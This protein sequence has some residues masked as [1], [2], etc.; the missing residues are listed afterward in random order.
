MPSLF[1][2]FATL[3]RGAR[4]ALP[5]LHAAVETAK[6][7]SEILAEAKELGFTIR[8][9]V[10]LDIIGTLRGNLDVRRYLRI[11]P[12]SAILNPDFIPS[13]IS[14]TLR[15]FSYTVLARMHDEETG[16]TINQHITVSSNDALSKEDIL[17][18]A[19]EYSLSGKYGA[20]IVIDNLSVTNAVK[21]AAF[22]G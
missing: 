22:G 6:T 4:A 8:R 17:S 15:D 13:S 1:D 11:T 20:N 12:H 16:E 19:N 7:A 10:G 5:Y 21:S 9:Q 3:T 18:K 2:L 14:K